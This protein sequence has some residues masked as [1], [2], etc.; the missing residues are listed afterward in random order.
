MLN[1]LAWKDV[2]YALFTFSTRSP[3]W[4]SLLTWKDAHALLDCT[5]LRPDHCI[6][7]WARVGVCNICCVKDS[8]FYFTIL[9]PKQSLN[10]GVAIV[11]SIT[12]K[13]RRPGGKGPEPQKLYAVGL[14][15]IKIINTTTIFNIIDYII[16]YIDRSLADW[17]SNFD[18][19]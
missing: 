16:L 17:R 15:Y 19:I 1:H 9:S 14:I 12:N 11:G 5:N 13:L 18:N 3:I 6:P 2:E 7:R 8:C 10:R 4:S